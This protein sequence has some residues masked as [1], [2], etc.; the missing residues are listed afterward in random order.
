MCEERIFSY[1]DDPIQLK[2]LILSDTLLGDRISTVLTLWVGVV[3]GNM[4]STGTAA[5]CRSQHTWPQTTWRKG[6]EQEWGTRWRQFRLWLWWIDQTSLSAIWPFSQRHESH[7]F[8]TRHTRY[9]NHLTTRPTPLVVCDLPPPLWH[10]STGRV[11][12]ANG[13]WGCVV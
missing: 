2:R 10:F 4:P 12:G 9:T 6:E 1:T 5:N 3:R 11:A 13:L 7:T 8:H